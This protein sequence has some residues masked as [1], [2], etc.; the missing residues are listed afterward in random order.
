MSGIALLS[1]PDQ[2][3]LSGVTPTCPYHTQ[4]KAY[5]K[6]KTSACVWCWNVGFSKDLFGFFPRSCAQCENLGLTTS[7]A[8]FEQTQMF[9]L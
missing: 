5:G 7:Q 6:E 3:L 2:M 1:D 4:E 9:S 8:V